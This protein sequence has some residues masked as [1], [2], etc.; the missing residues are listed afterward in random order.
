MGY[1]AIL[2]VSFGG[3]EGPE[4]VEPFLSNV[5]RG[6]NVPAERRREVAQHYYELGGAS[7][8]GAATRAMAAALQTKLDAAGPRLPVYIGNRNWHPLLPDTLRRMAAEGVTSALAVVTSAFGSYSGCRQYLEDMERARTAV[9]ESAP[10][11]DK[12]RLFYNH[13]E[14]L[15]IWAERVAAALETAPAGSGLIFTAHS[16]P[17]DMARRGPYEEQLREACRLVAAACGR[18]QWTLAYQSRSGPPAQPWL[19][20]SVESALAAARQAPG[21][22][23]APIGFLS[24]HME[25][26]YDLDH[27]ARQQAEALQLAFTRV[28]T[29]GD[30]PRF[31]GLLQELIRERCD[32]GRAR[33]AVG[34][35]EAWPDV[36]PADCCLSP[37]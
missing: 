6:R 27:E 10:R 8:I 11:L 5:L 22:V 29:P 3:P 24:D 12:V 4:D 35:C 20:P 7:P 1:G 9:G 36:C 37:R 21:V 15:A 28:K 33:Q 26:V 18:S 2:L 32:P 13:P 30:H 19:E 25:V 17:L 31:A 34:Q 23:V 16:I 14:F